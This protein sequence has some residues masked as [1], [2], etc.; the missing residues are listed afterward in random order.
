MTLHTQMYGRGLRP[1]PKPTRM[2]ATGGI[3]MERRSEFRAKLRKPKDELLLGVV[4]KELQ[5]NV[6]KSGIPIC[7]V[8][9]ENSPWFV[10]TSKNS[11]DMIRQLLAV[12]GYRVGED[13]LQVG[14]VVHVNV[15]WRETMFRDEDAPAL[16]TSVSIVPESVVDFLGGSKP[17][18]FAQAVYAQQKTYG[19]V[20]S[21]EQAERV[22]RYKQAPEGRSAWDKIMD[23]WDPGKDPRI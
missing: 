22:A 14:D 9:F 10:H 15:N 21:P 5:A 16:V 11:I 12:N 23:F 4:I 20:V 8:T 19:G 3:T 1:V 2:D 6:S 17:Y 7:K 18:P 13:T